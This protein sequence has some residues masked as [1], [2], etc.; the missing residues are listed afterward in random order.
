MKTSYDFWFP[1]TEP[2]NY[3]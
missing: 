1:V 3:I 2:T